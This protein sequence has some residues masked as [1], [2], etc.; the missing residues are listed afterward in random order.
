MGKEDLIY[1]SQNR[2][3]FIANASLLKMNDTTKIKSFFK[4]I[5]RSIMVNDVHNLI[6]A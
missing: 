1:D 2:I 3:A 6:G 5:S 4:N